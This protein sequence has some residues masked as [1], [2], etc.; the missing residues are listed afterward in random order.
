MTAG[1]TSQ[2][3][4]PYPELPYEARRGDLSFTFRLA[5][6]RAERER[7]FALRQ[8]VYQGRSEYLLGSGGGLHPAE[9]RF[10]SSSMLFNCLSGG[11]VVAT[12][13]FT[14]REGAGWEV[15]DLVEL[16]A[17]PSVEPDRL[18]QVS[19][20]VVHPDL[21]GQQISEA[22][23]YLACFWFANCSPFSWYFAVCLPPLVRFYRHFGVEVLS[24]EALSL[25]GR[26]DNRYFLVHGSFR[27]SLHNLRRYLGDAWKLEPEIELSQPEVA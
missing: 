27:E 26:G 19:R 23:M 22:M 7:S 12:C 18:L 10:D 13:R 21:R 2:A 16:P 3:P 4:N 14:P 11:E 20:V 15:T 25:P 6:D 17:F 24:A 8:L 9:D 1:P 5:A